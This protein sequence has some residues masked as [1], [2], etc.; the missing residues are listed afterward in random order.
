MNGLRAMFVDSYFGQTPIFIHDCMDQ[1]DPTSVRR[2][3]QMMR[4]CFQF[5]KQTLT[6]TLNFIPIDTSFPR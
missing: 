4:P 2:Q 1:L 5:T 6:H 3:E